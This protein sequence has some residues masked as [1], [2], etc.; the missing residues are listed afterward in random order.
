MQKT[1]YSFANICWDGFLAIG[2]SHV[3]SPLCGVRGVLCTPAV[4]LNSYVHWFCCVWQALF[5][6]SHLFPLISIIVLSPLRHSFLNSKGR[7]CI[8]T[9]HLKPV[10]SKSLTYFLYIVYLCLSVLVA[11]FCNRNFPWWRLGK[12]LMYVCKKQN[13][14]RSQFCC[15]SFEECSV[16]IFFVPLVYKHSNSWQHFLH[17]GMDFKTRQCLASPRMYL[18]QATLSCVVHKCQLKALHLGWYCLS[19]L[20]V[21]RIHS[22]TMIT[23]QGWNQV[24]YQI[25]FFIFN[26]ICKSCFSIDL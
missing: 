24:R 21:C 7:L 26:R 15:V 5:P 3:A 25:V 14:I 1:K 20:A 8:K 9:S 6:W 18:S 11:I 23:N 16:C 19:F 4:S 13:I 17:H 12:A 22:S 10:F 2:R